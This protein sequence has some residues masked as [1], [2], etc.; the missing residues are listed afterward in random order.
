MFELKRE[1]LS[2]MPLDIDAKFEGNLTRDLKNGMW[3]LVSFYRLENSDFNLESKMAELNQNKNSKQLDQ[4]DAQRKL[5]F[6][7]EINE[8]HN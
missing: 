1:E 3:N 4:P 5:Y 2:F 6:T 8:K 7:L